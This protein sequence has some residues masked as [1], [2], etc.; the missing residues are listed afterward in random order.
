MLNNKSYV[1][2]FVLVFCA[3]F[4][5]LAHFQFFSARQTTIELYSQKQ[6]VLARQVALS[7]E[8]FFEEGIKALELVGENPIIR[9][10]DYGKYLQE[11]KNVFRK[12][13]HY[14]R[15]C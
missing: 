9:N 15:P 4:I 2:I 14:E 6:I 5:V 1:I 12:V 8:K 10:K 3:T 11:Y 13:G 7:V